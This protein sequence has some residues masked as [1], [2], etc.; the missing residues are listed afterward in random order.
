MGCGGRKV[1]SLSCSAVGER[2]IDGVFFW[3]FR[4]FPAVVKTVCTV[5]GVGHRVRCCTVRRLGPLAA[6]LKLA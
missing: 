4:F 5:R 3:G 2:L 1:S 6:L